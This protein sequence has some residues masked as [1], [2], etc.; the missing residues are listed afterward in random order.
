M[1][2]IA[3]ILTSEDK[4]H[5]LENFWDASP[6][7]IIPALILLCVKGENDLKA[8]AGSLLI[9]VLSQSNFSATAAIIDPAKCS[10]STPNAEDT[11][12]VT[13]QICRPPHGTNLTLRNITFGIHVFVSLADGFDFPVLSDALNAFSDLIEIESFHMNTRMMLDLANFTLLFHDKEP[14]HKQ[15]ALALFNKI[16]E[17]AQL[18]TDAEVLALTNSIIALFPTTEE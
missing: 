9:R 3:Q 8:A 18:E 7:E 10:N 15:K 14:P 5:I 13:R 4:V 12:I 16:H 2:A 17:I 11:S 1:S 6:C